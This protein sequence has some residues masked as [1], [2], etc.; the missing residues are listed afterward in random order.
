MFGFKK[1][2]LVMVDGEHYMLTD[3]YLNGNVRLSRLSSID[4]END[5]L[6]RT[7]GLNSFIIPGMITKHGFIGISP[8]IKKTLKNKLKLL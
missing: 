2:E 5:E 7:W 4:P 3:I 8:R 1:N 6:D